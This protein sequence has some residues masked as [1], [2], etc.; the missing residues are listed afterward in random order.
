MNR[1][2]EVV[3]IGGGIIGCSIAYYLAKEK[4]DV[5]VLDSQKV[6]GKS[7][8]A[9][10][11]MLGAHSEYKEFEH[12][13]PF[14]RSSQLL[15]KELVHEIKDKSGI[16]IELKEGG[17]LKLVYSEEEKRALQPILA[18]S[19]VEWMTASDV[20]EKVPVN[21]SIIGAAY[22]KEDV[23]VTPTSACNG[24]S[25]TAQLNGASIFE[26]TEVAEIKKQDGHYVIHTAK[27]EFEACYVVVASGVWSNRFFQQLGLTN[28]IIPVK[29]EC[30]AVI[31]EGKP[32]DHTLFYN[33]NYIV[34]RNNNKLVI[35]ATQ[36]WNDWDERPTIGGIEEIIQK[37]KEMMPSITEMKID[38]YW[39]G[40]R[41]MTFDGY[42]FIGAHPHGDNLFFA[43][44]HQRNGILMAP[45]TGKMIKDMIVGNQVDKTWVQAFQ[46][47]RRNKIS[48]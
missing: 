26:Y 34:Q 12:L 11:G 46:V 18:H 22:L 35:G 23:H 47:D 17:I 5:A 3:V 25:K 33:Q 19:T 36:K 30:L 9:A 45:A 32:L 4:I 16:D 24:L 44:G 40:F 10:A 7:T 39:A 2:F 14:V 37:A 38:S 1:K 48:L 29:G 42:P 15:Y 8:S 41:P 28:Q 43:A 13:Y 21:A 6:G 31:N 27:G 20:I